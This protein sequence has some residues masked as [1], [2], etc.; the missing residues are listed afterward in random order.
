MSE[1]RR[2]LTSAL[3]RG[4]RLYRSKASISMYVYQISIDPDFLNSHSK[5]Q[6]FP[7]TK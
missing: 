5:D 4:P 1:L 2:A 7:K 6:P 3:E